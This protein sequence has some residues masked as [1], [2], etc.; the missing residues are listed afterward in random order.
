MAGT[1][2]TF[3]MGKCGI[4][5][6]LGGEFFRRAGGVSF[7]MKRDGRETFACAVDLIPL[8]IASGAEG[9]PFSVDAERGAMDGI[10]G[11]RLATSHTVTVE[12]CE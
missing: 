11:D 10:D 2:E 1:G 6:T 9:F 7:G 12:N 4:A 3:F 5:I 8:G